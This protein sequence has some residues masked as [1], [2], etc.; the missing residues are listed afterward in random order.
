MGK[1]GPQPQSPEL[2]ALRGNPGKRAI[3]NPP[4]APATCPPCPKELEHIRG[5]WDRYGTM[6]AGL[7]ILRETDTIAW[8]SMWRTYDKYM[9]SGRAVSEAVESGDAERIKAAARFGALELQYLGVLIKLLDRFGM[10][11][12]SRNSIGVEA[13]KGDMKSEFEILRDR[14]AEKK[15]A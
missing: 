2:K 10:N 4:K 13:P 15:K 12:S 1:R 8:D 9:Q 7:G 11:P 3:P 6:L 5:E 14:L